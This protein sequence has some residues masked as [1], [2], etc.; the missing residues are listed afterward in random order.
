MEV[1]II[2]TVAPLFSPPRSLVLSTRTVSW[3]PN[4]TARRSHRR[5][6][7]PAWTRLCLC[8]PWRHQGPAT[9]CC[10]PPL[11][12]GARCLTPLLRAA[13]PRFLRW[14]PRPPAGPAS[15]CL[16]WCTTPVTPPP[17]PRPLLQR[18]PQR[19]PTIPHRLRLPPS[20][21]SRSSPWPLTGQTAGRGRPAPC[22]VSSRTAWARAGPAKP[23]P[24][25]SHTFTP[26]VT[27]RPRAPSNSA[28]RAGE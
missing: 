21:L 17:F 22:S 24:T 11:L 28:P 12:R 4:W 16:K 6:A 8:R 26:S 3:R 9:P 7:A 2:W 25:P 18:A 15:H 20:P 10:W 1:P 19:A 27:F 13:A 23:R 5:A 14:P